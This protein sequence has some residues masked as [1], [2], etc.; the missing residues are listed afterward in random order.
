MIGFGLFNRCPLHAVASSVA[1][2]ATPLR[3]VASPYKGMQQHATGCN[4]RQ[5]GGYPT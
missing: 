2:L 1:Q 4:G 5:I 3:C